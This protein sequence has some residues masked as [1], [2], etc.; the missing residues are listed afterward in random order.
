VTAVTLP[1]TRS[2]PARFW[3]A[4]NRGLLIA[5]AAFLTL[6]ALQLLIS[7]SSYGFF[8]FSYQSGGGA[9]LALAAMGQTLVVLGGGFDLSAGAVISLVNVVLASGMQEALGSQIAFGVAAILIGGLVGAFNGFF[10]AV[11]R[12]QSIVVTLSTMFIIQGVTL[13]IMDKPGGQ[14]APGFIAFLNGTAIPDLLPAP[15]VVLVVALLVWGLIRHSRFGTAIYAIGGDREAAASSGIR[16]RLVSF[17]NYVLAGCFYGAAGAFISA[18]TGSADPLVGA[19]L[20][21]EM[22]AAV[23]VG[24]TALGGGRGGCLGSVIGAYILMIVV[25]ILLVLNVS[26]YYSTVAEG[27]IL[28]LAVLGASLNRDSA[29]A[30]YLRIA[31]QRWKAWRDGTLPGRL[32]AGAAGIVFVRGSGRAPRLPAWLARH[33]ETLRYALPAYVALI[34][35]LA[36]TLIHY[37]GLDLHYLN[38]LLVLS[39]FLSILSLGQGSVI[40]TGGLDLSLPW[41]IALC[42]ILLAGATNGLNLPALWAVPAVL[43]VGALVGLVNGAG[44]VLLGLPPIVI[45]LATNGIVEGFAL[46]YS[47]GTPAGFAPP[48]L[49]WLMTG[50]F[51]HATPVVWVLLL[52]VIGG[53]VLLGRTAFGRR[54]YAVGNSARVAYLSG[55]NIGKT[56]IGAYVLSGLCAALVGILLAGFNGQASLGMGDE[57]LLPS[58]AVVVVGGALITGGRGHYLGMIGGVLLLTALQT[59]LAG[60]TLPH[61]VRDIIFGLV[62]LG[63][64][65]ALRDRQTR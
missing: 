25:N 39:C 38:S 45:T 8:D 17:M 48:A 50:S 23:V 63:A 35:V 54:I 18:Q 46:V 32:P 59:L 43:A 40:L 44:V 62:V 49:R 55:V 42:G 2:L 24:G 6:F 29:I 28:I 9:T 4:R 58:I 33:R 21:L 19:P 27:V 37:G 11:L 31:R 60:T 36:V 65:L 64:V 10:I 5:I 13:L 52:F 15:I 16:V 14:I 7:P 51:L 22:F 12:L 41:T 53:T 61:A 26:A 3:L 47:N 34:L 1:A 30:A 57:Y 20:L 56:L